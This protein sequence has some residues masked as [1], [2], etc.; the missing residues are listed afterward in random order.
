MVALPSQMPL[1]TAGR[2]TLPGCEASW[3]ESCIR[4]AA[5]DAGH[6]DWWF[7]EDIA[8]SVVVYLRDRFAGSAITLEDMT[9]KLRAILVKL[10]FNDIGQCIALRP[11]VLVVSLRDVAEEAQGVE[12][13][14]YSLLETRVEEMRKMGVQR[15]SLTDTR[16][17]LMHL[18]G[19]GQW[20]RACAELEATL[21]GYLQVRLAG[22]D[23]FA[24]ELV[25]TSR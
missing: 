18:L 21:L 22:A 17:G 4:R 3:V 12:L 23:D 10:G 7:A 14:F 19:C 9:A 16:E 11:E 20:T 1:I 6:E 25:D 13:L 2:Y 8:Q 15:L 24:V 5:A